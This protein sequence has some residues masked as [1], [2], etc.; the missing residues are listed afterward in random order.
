MAREWSQYDISQ[1]LTRNWSVL[2]P[3]LMG[4][5]HIYVGAQDSFYSEGAVRLLK[6][7][8]GLLGSD[9]VIE[10]VPGKDHFTLRDAKLMGRISKEMVETLRGAGIG[11]DSVP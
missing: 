1:K 9:A 6:Q 11:T 8:L 3:K 10:I 2:G 7:A 5:L 4:K